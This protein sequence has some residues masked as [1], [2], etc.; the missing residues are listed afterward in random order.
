MFASVQLQLQRTTNTKDRLR[1]QLLSSMEVLWHTYSNSNPLAY[2]VYGPPDAL[3]DS[4]CE[5]FNQGRES[6]E[7]IYVDDI[8]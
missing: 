4:L 6:V 8:S 7:L 1:F 3:A 2:D 5:A